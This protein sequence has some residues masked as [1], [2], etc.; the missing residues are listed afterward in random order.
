MSTLYESYETGYDYVQQIGSTYWD[1]QT[2]KPTTSHTIKTVKLY[3]QRYGTVSGNVVVS[4]RATTSGLPSGSDLCSGSVAASG[5]SDSGIAW[6]T[7]DL[8]AGTLLTA[9]TTYAIVMAATGG[10]GFLNYIMW[11]CDNTS[12]TY[13]NGSLVAS[14]NSGSSWSAITTCDM[15]FEEWGNPSVIQVSLAGTLNLSG[16]VIRKPKIKK[17]RTLTSSGTIKRKMKIGKAGT[18][19]LSGAVR[20]RRFI[21]LAGSLSF[22]GG[23]S[24]LRRLIGAGSVSV[25]GYLGEDCF[26]LTKFTAIESGTMSKI[27][28]YSDASLY[29]KVAVYADNNGEPDV[30]LSVVN[31]STAISTGWS[32]ISIPEISVVSG[33]SYWLAFNSG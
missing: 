23:I 20:L 19:N 26:H 8:G 21:S 10:D 32:T 6:V 15:Y 13:A 5:I 9:N 1:A 24:V 2:F 29:A 3:L 4:I 14:T 11:G 12:P 27:K 31:T 17:A 16:T 30:L 7:F 33:R 28:I 25:D 18:L 22:T